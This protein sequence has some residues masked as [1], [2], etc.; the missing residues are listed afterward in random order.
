MIKA[1]S[2]SFEIEKI[3]LIIL[4]FSVLIFIIIF[5]GENFKLPQTTKNINS[6]DTVEVR[7]T[8]DLILNS[9]GA[10]EIKRKIVLIN[11]KKTNRS[12]LTAY[13]N[14]KIDQTLIIQNLQKSL[15]SDSIK[16]RG[17]TTTIKG[18]HQIHLSFKNK[19]FETLNLQIK[20][21]K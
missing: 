16:V 13:F 6:F 20:K 4:A 9:N 5:F 21:G 14:D 3:N 12:D 7:K 15:I 10:K 2:K 19:I 18:K 8:V 17:A 1:V 11:S